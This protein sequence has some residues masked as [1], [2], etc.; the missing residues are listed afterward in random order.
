M[1]T[2]E[3]VDP[4]SDPE[5]SFEDA[6]AAD[7]VGA[8][9]LDRLERLMTVVVFVSIAATAALWD[10]KISLGW[11]T[12][13]LVSWS[14]VLVVRRLMRRIISKGTGKTMAAV[15]M[16]F[17]LVIVLVVVYLVLTR[18]PA[19]PIA[20]AIGH[21]VVVAGLVIGSVVLAPRP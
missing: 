18:L 6:L 14:S 3:P 4:P 9:L 2:S 11:A 5:P 17:K 10:L 21:V 7:P 20:F 12:G 15:I 19:S 16:G 8:P 13:A 1:T